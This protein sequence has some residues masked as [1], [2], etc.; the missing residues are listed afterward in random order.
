[1]RRH[2]RVKASAGDSQNMSPTA[3][4]AMRS[5]NCKAPISSAPTPGRFVCIQTGCSAA[6]QAY[7]EADAEAA[8]RLGVADRK[9]TQR[10]RRNHHRPAL[11][12][13]L[14]HHS[15]HKPIGPQSRR[16]SIGL[17]LHAYTLHCREA[18]PVFSN[19]YHKANIQ[20]HPLSK[21]PAY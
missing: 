17:M 10:Q 11:L 7:A 21:Y 8:H 13:S 19:Y 12:R 20:L 6:A 5:Q 14:F 18:Q 2:A 9:G 4:R 1:M 16:L 3:C 15:R